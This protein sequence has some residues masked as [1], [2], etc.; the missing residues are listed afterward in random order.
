MGESGTIVVRR[1]GAE[2]VDLAAEILSDAFAED[3][4]GQWITPDP[5]WA[6]WCWPQLLPYL[7]DSIDVYVTTCGRGAAMWVPPGG[8]L[9]IQPGLGMA[10]GAWRQFGIRPIYRLIRMM[11]T[12]QKHH[13]KENHY[14]LFAVGVRSGAKGQGIGSAL[15]APV[16]RKCDEQ[17]VGAYLESSNK[18]N[19][20]FYQRHGF[21]VV[22][23]I[24]LPNHGPSMWPMYRE[25]VT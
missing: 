6:Q 22:R 17:K 10:W 18:R 8:K 16:L 4:V 20:S 23:K 9:D 5:A 14:Y 19:L 21:K 13:P 11:T 2:D 1:G 15:L 12:L 25:P 24:T 7:V 3:P